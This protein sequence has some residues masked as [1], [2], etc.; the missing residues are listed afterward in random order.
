MEDA[1]CLGSEEGGDLE[2]PEV[3]AVED[4]HE[5]DPGVG[6]VVV[7]HGGPDGAPHHA[8]PLLPHLHMRDIKIL[9]LE[10]LNTR[11]RNGSRI[12]RVLLVSV[13]TCNRSHIYHNRRV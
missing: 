11:A 7:P 13:P 3:R 1:R 9:T 4:V 12:L 6:L 8:A 5:G 2:T 10:T